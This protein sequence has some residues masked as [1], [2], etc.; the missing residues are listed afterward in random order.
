MPGTVLSTLQIVTYLVLTAILGIGGGETEA[1]SGEVT[2]KVTQLVSG[3]ARIPAQTVGVW[4][5]VS[6]LFLAACR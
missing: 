5:R 3:T 6:P 1:Q 4:V 2:Y